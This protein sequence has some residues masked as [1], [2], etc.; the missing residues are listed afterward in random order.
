M[1]SS[2]K[3]QHDWAIKNEHYPYRTLQLDMDLWQLEHPKQYEKALALVDNPDNRRGGLNWEQYMDT[4]EVDDENYIRDPS[5]FT[6]DFTPGNSRPQ[7]PIDFA[8]L[9]KLVVE[10]DG[11]FDHAS[12]GHIFIGVRQCGSEIESENV[13]DHWHTAAF[14]YLAGISALRVDYY[15]HSSHL[16]LEECRIYEQN[17]FTDIN[18]KQK[19]VGVAEQHEKGITKKRIDLSKKQIINPSVICRDVQLDDIMVG[20]GLSSTGRTPNAVLVEGIQ[21]FKGAWKKIYTRHPKEAEKRMTSNIELILKTWPKTSI[22]SYF[23]D[24][25]ID[26]RDRCDRKSIKIDD[27]L[28]LAFLKSTAEGQNGK[29]QDHFTESKIDKTTGAVEGPK[30][31]RGKACQ[32]ISLRIL[33]DFNNYIKKVVKDKPYFNLQTVREMYYGSLSD[34]HIKASFTGKQVTIAYQCPSCGNTGKVKVDK[35]FAVVSVKVD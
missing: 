28:M 33:I 19:P 2:E 17:K 4:L 31:E 1:I 8:H 34:L 3:A 22:S 32:S 9:F 30:N 26:F 13:V 29:T 25:L 10:S 20:L 6:K 24:G 18:E 27:K 35:D 21:S 14:A 7:R 5:T 15:V 11:V 23:F 12:A 16:S